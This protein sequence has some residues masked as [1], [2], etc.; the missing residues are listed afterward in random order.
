MARAR[1]ERV[2]GIDHVVVDVTLLVEGVLS[3]SLGALFYPASV[4]ERAPAAWNSLPI[5]ADHPSPLGVSGRDPAVWGRQL[6]GHLFNAAASGGR[7]TAEA[8]LHLGLLR[9]HGPPGLADMVLAGR[10]VE[11]STGL[12]AT[13]SPSPPGATYNGVPASGVVTAMTPDHLAVLG[14][15]QAGA[16]SVDMGCGLNLMRRTA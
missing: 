13:V 8:W 7:L 15:G 3:G 14:G 2:A 11:V 1:R 16:C 9:L 10:P 5:L 6:L 4:I 12:H